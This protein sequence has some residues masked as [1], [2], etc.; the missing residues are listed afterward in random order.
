MAANFKMHVVG[1]G[2]KLRISLI[3]DFDGTSAHQVIG[4]VHK[5]SK[6][7]RAICIDTSKLRKVY[8]FGRDI[9]QSDLAVLKN[10][11]SGNL[12]FSGCHAAE[13]APKGTRVV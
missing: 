11:H 1:K 6:R 8:P 4:A 13:L 2:A 5:H 9:L 3:G 7:T 10:S 12:M